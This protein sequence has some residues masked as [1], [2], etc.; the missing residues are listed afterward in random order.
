MVELVIAF[1]LDLLVG[2]PPYSWHPVRIIGGWIQKTESWLRTH[3]PDASLAGWIQAIFI[4]TVVY[5]FVWFL[6]EVAFQ[7]SPMLKSILVIYFLYSS[8]SVKDLASEARRVHLALRN[9]KLEA[10]RE[11]LSRIVGRDTQNLSETEVVRGTV[12]TVAESFVDGI[13]SP[14][15]YVALGG[16]PLVMAYKAINTLDSMVGLRT[17]EYR[18]Y[19]RAAARLD[20]IANWVPAR[21]S[22]LLI[23]LAAF[24]VSGRAQEAWHVAT[25]NFLGAGFANGIIPEAAFAGALGIE[26]GGINYYSGQKFET[27]KL[28]IAMR[29]LEPSDIRRAVDLMNASSWAALVFAVIL[30]LFASLTFS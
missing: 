15:F 11:S 9:H 13:L 27:R 22:W 4:P 17:P 29:S 12:E 30:Q 25:Q 2:D 26:L 20:A 28:G 8:I 21:I 6:T 14:L 1:A 24:F 23:G 7:I 19:G 3:I 10:A 18:E 5:V 16:A